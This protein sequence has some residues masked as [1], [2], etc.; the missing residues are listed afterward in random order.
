[1][2]AYEREISELQIAVTLHSLGED[3]ILSGTSHKFSPVSLRKTRRRNYVTDS[4][5]ASLAF[6]G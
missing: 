1:V 2:R 3:Q 4:R 6:Q 5:A